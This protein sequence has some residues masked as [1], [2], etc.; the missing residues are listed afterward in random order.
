MR[1]KMLLKKIR[2]ALA[3]ICAAALLTSAVFV[4]SVEAKTADSKYNASHIQ[5]LEG[6]KVDYSQ[7]LD[8]SVVFKLPD[9]VKDSDEISVIV[10]VDTVSIMDAYEGTDK[11][12]SF[13]DYALSSSDSKKIK[14]EIAS[15][16]AEVLSLLDS[17]NIKYTAGEDYST[18][19][20]GFELVI[21][22]EDF[23][24]TCKSLSKGMDVIVGE[25][26][27]PAKTEL[28]E[29][30]VNVFDTGIFDSSNSG[31]D[32]SGMVVAVLDTGLDSN[33]TAFSPKNFTS[34]N[35]GLTYEDVAAVIDDT[36]ASEQLDGLT[37]DDVYINEKVPFGF[38]YADSDPDVYST[39]N[40]HGTHVSGVI[41]GN[42]DT[43][44]G[45]APNAQLV[46]MKIFS[47]VIDTART[48]WILAALE[49]CVVLGVDVINMSIGTACGF[50][51]ESDEESVDG[52][53]DKIRDA[54]ISMV[55]A[56]SNSFSSAYGSEANG[57][58]GLTSN[59][60]T[61]TVGSPSTYEGVMSVA[62]ISG[63]ETPY[64]KYGDTIIYFT[65]ST[66]SA[67]EENHFFD[68]LLKDKDSAKI[69]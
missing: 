59:P 58:L 38:D 48:A 36:A 35:L 1:N 22:A 66:N 24:K 8:D 28:V 56:A 27:E 3:G 31:Y 13:K 60:D 17:Q 34:K 9:N 52:I 12:M 16:K 47:D 7:Y 6:L 45:V 61:G 10:T 50:S 4:P 14:K 62:S 63:V 64:I 44:R 57:N 2:S 41:V 15:Q 39:H 26:Y 33:H 30:E 37:V 43:I 40:N 19:L 11:T 67:A 53:Y 29:N 18:I 42:D 5:K 46:S 49:D 25:V 51:R 23:A 20:S 65:E 69:E 54:G 55:V 68:T 21:K 32:G